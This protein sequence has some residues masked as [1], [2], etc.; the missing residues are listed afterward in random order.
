MEITVEQ[1]SCEYTFKVG[2][3]EVMIISGITGPQASQILS[4][5]KIA[6]LLVS[7]DTKVETMKEI[8][9][10]VKQL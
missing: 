6:A 2:N 7:T 10:I 3:S 4:G 1:D 5:I 8:H 9:G